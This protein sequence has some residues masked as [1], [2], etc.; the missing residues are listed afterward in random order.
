MGN[1]KQAIVK[2]LRNTISE[3]IEITGL[4]VLEGK[5]ALE[6]LEGYKISAVVMN[7]YVGRNNV[8]FI[9]GLIDK[10]LN[11][12]NIAVDV[13]Y[14]VLNEVFI[15]FRSLS[16]GTILSAD[17][18]YA[19]KQKA[20]KIPANAV[21]N[22]NDIQGKILK[23]NIGQGVIIRAD[24]LTDN[25]SIKRGQKVEVVVEGNSVVIS[26]HGVLRSDAIIGGAARV[27]CDISKKE[28]S[29]ILISP[30]T[31]RVKI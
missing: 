22:R 13:S 31:V 30:N 15:T 7:G 29:G 10:R 12:K 19:I 11:R 18:F 23:A 16:K 25:V 8:N 3:D 14:D 9:V 2:E 28:V 5:D 26:T 24:H 21:L 6:N 1:I 27:L 17:D 4:R 20:S